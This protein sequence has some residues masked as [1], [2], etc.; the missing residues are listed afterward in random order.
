VIPIMQPFHEK[1]PTSKKVIAVNASAK[2]SLVKYSSLIP[3]FI[4]SLQKFA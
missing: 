4:M 1:I 3:T 2:N